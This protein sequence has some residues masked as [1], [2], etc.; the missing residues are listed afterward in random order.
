VSAVLR[1]AWQYDSVNEVLKNS[2]VS[3]NADEYSDDGFMHIPLIETYNEFQQV[4]TDKVKLTFQVVIDHG[5]ALPDI[6]VDAVSIETLYSTLVSL[7]KFNYEQYNKADLFELMPVAP[8]R[9][10]VKISSE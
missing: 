5:Y 2:T 9:A 1:A 6:I 7:K 3:V 10:K 4:G 8:V